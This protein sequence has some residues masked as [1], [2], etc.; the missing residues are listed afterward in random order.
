MFNSSNSQTVD[1]NDKLNDKSFLQYHQN[2][3]Y[4]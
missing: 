2:K 1:F 4:F 3:D